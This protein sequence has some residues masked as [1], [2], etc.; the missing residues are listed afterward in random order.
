MAALTELWYIQLSN[1]GLEFS[2]KDTT[3]LLQTR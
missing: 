3:Q 1:L 2:V